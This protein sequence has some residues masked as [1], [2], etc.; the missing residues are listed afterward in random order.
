[1]RHGPPA[2]TRHRLFRAELQNP[3]K[4]Q[5]LLG[6][7]P[8]N[9]SENL[10]EIVMHKHGFLGGQHLIGCETQSA[11]LKLAYPEQTYSYPDLT[12]YTMTAHPPCRKPPS[13]SSHSCVGPYLSFTNIP[14]M[15][16]CSFS[17]VYTNLL[18]SIHERNERPHS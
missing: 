7:N 3:K 9:M 10:S 1:M 4:I 6:L 16:I 13:V 15:I 5:N 2:G 14:P 18:T 12:S 8:I 11:K 17:P